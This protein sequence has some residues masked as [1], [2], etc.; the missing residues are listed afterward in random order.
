[1]PESSDLPSRRSPKTLRTFEIHVISEST[2]SLASHITSVVLSQFPKSN[3]QVHRH[4]F[5]STVGDLRN[6]LR[7]MEKSAIVLSAITNSSLKRSLVN[8]CDRNDVLY[9]HLLDSVVDFFS[10]AVNQRPVRDV[11]RVHSCDDDYFRRIEA[12]EFTLQHDDN[13]RLDTINEADVV[14]V[15]VSRVGK[16][17]LAAYLGSLGFRV[18]NVAIAPEAKVAREVSSCRKLAIGLTMQAKRLAQIRERRFEKNRFKDAL[19][20][21][22]NSTDYFS[23]RAVTRELMFA[24]SVFR[25]LKIPKLDMTGLTIEESAAHVLN[26]LHIDQD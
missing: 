6:I 8:W 14:L 20:R 22:P 7:S 9:F 1:M 25:K 16:T 12:W 18:A 23:T 24:E 5:C 17:P 10:L 19:S 11:S 21:L 2:G 15:G 3:Y 13:R 4:S 26:M